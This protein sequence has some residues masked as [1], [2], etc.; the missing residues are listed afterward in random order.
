MKLKVLAFLL[1]ITFIAFSLPGCGDKAEAPAPQPTPKVIVFGEAALFD[2]DKADLMSQGQERLTA[3]REEA[4]A[5]AGEANP[6]ADN[7][8]KKG[9]AKNRRVEIEVIGTGK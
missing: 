1:V 7:A 5:G 3:Y 8:P 9:K 2:F 4:K 6:M